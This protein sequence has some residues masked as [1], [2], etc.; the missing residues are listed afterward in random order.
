MVSRLNCKRGKHRMHLKV[1]PPAVFV[2][3]VALLALGHWLLPALSL[4]FPGQIALAL[5]VGP[6]GL[7]PAIQALLEFI[8]KKT[9]VNP[10]APETATK[11]VTGGIYGIS[12]NPMYLGLFCMLLG[13]AL[14]LGTLTALVILP[15]FIWYLTEFQI[16]PEEASLRKLFGSDYEDYANRV[17]RWI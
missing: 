9:T 3:A 11:L 7:I 4:Q 5:T 13:V 12:R 8:A 15:A 10:R 14:F 1:P 2:I 17:R 16:K 6:A